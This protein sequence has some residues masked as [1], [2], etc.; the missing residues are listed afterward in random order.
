MS[1]RSISP[2]CRSAVALTAL[3]LAVIFIQLANSAHG[4][5]V[6]ASVREENHVKI[7][8]PDGIISAQFKDE[9]II[10]A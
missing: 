7:S 3:W 10:L 4:S 1:R 6:P 9:L 2:K 8:A 5:A